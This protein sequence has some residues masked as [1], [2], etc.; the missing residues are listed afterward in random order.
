MSGPFFKPEELLPDS[1][2]EDLERHAGWLS[3]DHFDKESGLLIISIQS[4]VIKTKHHTVLVDTCAGNHKERPNWEPFHQLDLP[5]LQRL[6]D[7]G[8]HPDSVDFVMCTHLHVDHV[9]WNTRL[10]DGRWVPTFPNAKYVFAKQEYEF[11]EQV[12][13]KGSADYSA[14]DALVFNDSVLPV[15][16]AGQTEM[17]EGSHALNDQLKIDPAPGHTPGSCTLKLT[18]NGEEALFAGDTMHHPLQV[19]HPEWNS[20]F[21]MDPETARTTR[22]RVLEEAADRNQLL[23]PGHFA[24]PGAFRITRQDNGFAIKF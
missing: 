6:E 18:S 10:K 1:R 9:G 24:P 22:R 13:T 7:A 4:W 16:E 17:I 20:G 8:V 19:Y 14:E 21:C 3:P 5:Y 2:A 15:V 23:L 12:A 11:W